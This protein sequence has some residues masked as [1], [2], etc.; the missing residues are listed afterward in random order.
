MEKVHLAV[1]RYV[2][3]ERLDLRDDL[4]QMLH[5]VVVDLGS[6][7]HDHGSKHD[8]VNLALVE[9]NLALLA[10]EILEKLVTEARIQLFTELGRFELLVKLKTI[11]SV[12]GDS[13]IV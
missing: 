11:I 5:I 7:Y 2:D 12:D 13:H 1:G 4:A 10:A 6:G 3:W 9:A 8:G